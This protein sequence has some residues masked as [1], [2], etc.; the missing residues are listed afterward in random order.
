MGRSGVRRHGPIEYE[1]YLIN[2]DEGLCVGCGKCDGI[3]STDVFE[4]VVRPDREE[5]LAVVER[6]ENCLNCQ[7]CVGICPTTA[8]TI[9]EI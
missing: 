4:L 2:V 8:I 1:I 5:R 6:S 7:G 3:C 9:T